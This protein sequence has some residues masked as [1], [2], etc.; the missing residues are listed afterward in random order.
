MSDSFSGAVNLT[1]AWRWQDR[2]SAGDLD[3]ATA[4]AVAPDGS[5]FLAKRSTS[6]AADRASIAESS[7][8]TT[9]ATSRVVVSKL[10]GRD[11][12]E[13]W[14]LEEEESSGAK[15]ALAVAVGGDGDVIIA[16]TSGAC[17]SET[18][19]SLA[20]GS[21]VLAAFKL[22]GGDGGEI[23]RYHGAFDAS[24]SSTSRSS[25]IQN[26]DGGNILALAV[27]SGGSTFFVGWASGKL[28]GATGDIIWDTDSHGSTGPYQLHACTVDSDDNVVA[29]GV[30]G[31]S[32]ADAGFA[33]KIDGDDGDTI[34]TWQ[35][36]TNDFDE[37]LLGVAVDAEGDAYAAGGEGVSDVAGVQIGNSSVVVK[38][39]GSNG[40]EVWRYSG[41]PATGGSIFNSVAVDDA[42]DTVIAAGVTG[43]VWD[44]L[45][46]SEGQF[47]FLA[48]ALNATT[49]EEISHWQ[50]GTSSQDSV[51]F[52]EF[53]SRGGLYLGGYSDG[54]WAALST[55][56]S[57]GS[58]AGTSS[59]G[60]S[61]VKFEPPGYGE[62]DNEA[63]PATVV[64]LAATFALALLALLFCCIVEMWRRTRPGALKSWQDSRS[65]LQL[66]G[67]NDSGKSTP[68]RGDSNST[69]S[70]RGGSSCHTSHSAKSSAHHSVATSPTPGDRRQNGRPEELGISLRGIIS[71]NSYTSTIERLSRRPTV[72]DA[73]RRRH[74][75]ELGSSVSSGFLLSPLDENAQA[76]EEQARLESDPRTGQSPTPVDPSQ[77]KLVVAVSRGEGMEVQ[78]KAVAERRRPHSSTPREIPKATE[79]TS[80]AKPRTLV[81]IVRDRGRSRYPV[82]GSSLSSSSGF[83]SLNSSAGASFAPPKKHLSPRTCAPSHSARSTA[84]FA[85]ETSAPATR[86]LS[87]S[88]SEGVPH[89]SVSGTDYSEWSWYAGSVC[90]DRS[91]LQSRN[92]S[93]SPRKRAL[94][95][96]LPRDVSTK[97][98]TTEDHH[99]SGKL[100]PELSSPCERGLAQMV[101]NLR[102]HSLAR[103]HAMWDSD[104][105]SVR[106]DTDMSSEGSDLSV[107][108]F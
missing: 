104:A 80:I 47:D 35:D 37:V 49:G 70:P 83:S 24:D 106:R 39:D 95:L 48:V 105:G 7:S 51:G 34:W 88:M 46:R 77:T 15:G 29:A 62:E 55:A 61:L 20:G 18:S 68:I 59:G 74:M 26:A 71:S 40:R 50:G 22:S 96:V 107:T 13:M 45:G 65:G 44:P 97:G 75:L 23:W 27:D 4:G 100:A 103:C 56:T 87:S 12:S 93:L 101:D 84:S 81:E 17:S 28:D 33:A 42:T 1:E 3:G 64:V 31:G 5:I 32:T 86:Q 58:E 2:I 69:P 10:D 43:G 11:G 67:A 25:S 9:S 76:D 60:I 102:L 92:P 52:A 30:A 57:D 8:G 108:P 54:S 72:E 6:A 14:A 89:D 36:E 78:P 53:D 38:L 21:C 79:G 90:T 99:P 66:P 63:W 82:C 41:G 94:S 98:I 19:A 85:T 73:P 91:R 16:G